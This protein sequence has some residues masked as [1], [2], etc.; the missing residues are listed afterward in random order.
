MTSA[1]RPLLLTAASTP[2]EAACLLI[3]LERGYQA[4]YQAARKAWRTPQYRP[5]FAMA[6]ELNQLSVDAH[7]ETF[8]ATGLRQ[9]G[10]GVVLPAT[11]HR[12]DL[13]A[14]R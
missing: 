8:Y 10:A 1:D 12:E 6:D 3:I 2:Q 11:H 13:E 14:G 5:L 7:W 9:P 4:A